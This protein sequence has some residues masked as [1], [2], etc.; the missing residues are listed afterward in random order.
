MA[1]TKNKTSLIFLYSI[2]FITTLI[3]SYIYID[4]ANVELT[5]YENAKTSEIKK[6]KTLGEALLF[7]FIGFGYLFTGIFMF[8]KPRNPIPYLIIIVGTIAVVILYYMR[9]YG[10]PIPFTNGIVIVDFSTDWRDVV[11]K[12]C[13][14][15][16]VVPTTVLLMMRKSLS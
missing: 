2:F 7:S 1:K 12:I 9:I 5:A 16:L 4:H 3:T 8:L 6:T 13:Q 14:Q 11:T 10:I 15:I